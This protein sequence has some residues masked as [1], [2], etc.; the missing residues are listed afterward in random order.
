MASRSLPHCGAPVRV[1]RRFGA[2]NAF[3]MRTL[4]DKAGTTLAPQR[5]DPVWIV[6]LVLLVHQ[7]HPGEKS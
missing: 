5:S 2:L 6:F 7:I 1:A 3:L 4:F